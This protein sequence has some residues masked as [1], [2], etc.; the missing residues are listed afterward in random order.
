MFQQSCFEESTLVNP[1]SAC[2]NYFTGDTLLV[3]NEMLT[4]MGTEKKPQPARITRVGDQVDVYRNL[5]RYEL[6]S[7]KQRC[8]ELKG[9]VSGYA[10][11]VVIKNPTFAIGEKS[12]LRVLETGNSR[13]VHAFVRGQ[14]Q[15][16]INGNIE[17]HKLSNYLRVSYSPYVGGFFYSLARDDQGSLIKESIKPFKTPEKYLYAIVNGADVI[18]T[19]DCVV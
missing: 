16:G 13:N 19:N 7:I 14:F 2:L 12:R 8:G 15:N 17:V 4:L 5:N 10:Q 3:N 11:A 18:L 9:K 1:S 6:F